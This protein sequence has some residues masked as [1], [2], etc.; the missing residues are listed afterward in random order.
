MSDTQIGTMAQNITDSF[1]QVAQLITAESYIAGSAFAAASILKFKSHK[2][3][4][5][6]I[7]IG[8]PIALVAVAA[9]LLFLPTI[10]TTAGTT[11]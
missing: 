5:T 7:P 10:L 1:G 8:T 3:N 4:P 9:A 6:Q 2:D 11:E